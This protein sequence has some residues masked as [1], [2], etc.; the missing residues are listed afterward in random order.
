VKDFEQ[1]KL[2][3]EKNSEISAR[4]VDGLLIYYAA[5]RNNLESR[6]N[7]E[8][9]SYRHVTKKFQVEW[10]NM[11]KSQYLG[12]KIFKK[13]GLITSY[14]DHTALKK[15]NQE[16][17]KYLEIQAE[18][19]WKFSFSYIKEEPED[20]F[21]IME[22][23]FSGDEFLLYSPST[24]NILKAGPA[25]LWLNLIGF[26]GACWQSYGPIGAYRSFEPDDIFFFATELNQ[27]IEDEEDLLSYLED[28]PVPFMML[29][30]GS[31]YPLLANKKDQVIYVQAEYA[32]EGMDTKSL[33]DSFIT[34]YNKGVYRI[35][36]KKWNEP[37]HFS[38]AYYNEN[39]KT[40]LLSAMTDK[41]FKSL[42][43]GL[44]KYG[45]DFS[46]DP[47]IRVNLTMVTTASDIL[48]KKLD[49]MEY[50]KLFSRKSSPAE[51]E[52][53]EKMNLLLKYVIPDINAGRE[54][55]IESLAAKA[56]MDIETAREIIAQIRKNF[57]SKF[58]NKK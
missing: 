40:V 44:N 46:E 53:L 25:I 15:L 22:D 7:Q 36:L 35:S 56:G 33:T 3:C 28:H 32:I 24:S 45:Y 23:V 55:D 30:A 17:R 31:N 19:P 12:H 16:E 20:D 37:P 43:D 21:Y 38:Q 14:L 52:N 8:F 5:E 1:I 29:L 41:G 6:M 18:N 48:K 39:K 58:H 10:V 51:E 11:L 54:P 13:G 47:F 9:D 50:E 4:V 27:N 34:E 2:V 49:L 26:N 42:V 57:N